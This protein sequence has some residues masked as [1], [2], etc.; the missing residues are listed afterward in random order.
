MR[1]RAAAL[2]LVG[3]LCGALGLGAAR[4][5]V[6]DAA[7]LVFT[8][9]PGVTLDL[10][11]DLD[12]DTIWGQIEGRS[13]VLEHVPSGSGA[14]YLEAGEGGVDAKGRAGRFQLWMKGHS[15]MLSW[16]T[17]TGTGTGT[18]ADAESEILF[19]D[20]VLQ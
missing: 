6:H 3:A 16:V 4:A 2:A 11:H 10:G 9:A 18:G 13:V 12:N 19:P 5:E 14:R 15:A 17:G 7:P 8:C 1:Q 20:C